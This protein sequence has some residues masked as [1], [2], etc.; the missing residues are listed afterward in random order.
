MES[1]LGSG[2]GKLITFYL[3]GKFLF[4]TY[5][6][7]GLTLAT[8]DKYRSYGHTVY[9][10]V[11]NTDIYK[12]INIKRVAEEEGGGGQVREAISELSLQYKQQQMVTL[13]VPS[14][15]WT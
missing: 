14:R 3:L 1:L 5:Y 4:N 12:Q 10:Q 9:H 7:P 6:V 15:A 8:G 13:S 2:C 11:E